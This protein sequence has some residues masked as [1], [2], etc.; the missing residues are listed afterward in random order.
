MNA[1]TESLPMRMRRMRDEDLPGVIENEEAAYAH[2]WTLGIMRDCMRVGYQC[3]VGQIAG[4][5]M[6]HGI[7]SLAAGESHVLNICIHPDWQGQGHGR[8]MLEHLMDLALQQGASHVFLEVRASNEVAQQLYLSLGFNEI[9]Q[10]PGYYP[11]KQGR[12]TALIFAKT[13]AEQAARD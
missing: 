4:R 6:A 10:R 2:P 12:E 5:V 7:M 1:V 9:A 13:L 11:G 8:R 3:V